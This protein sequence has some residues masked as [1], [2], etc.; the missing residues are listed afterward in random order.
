MS[1]CLLLPLVGHAAIS[2]PEEVVR[3]SVEGLRQAIQR[4]A[5]LIDQDPDRVIPL[6]EQHIMPNVNLD[7][8]VRLI[9]GSHWENAS[10]SQRTA[11]AVTFSQALL[12]TYG[13]HAKFY[14]DAV[15]DYLGVVPI[16]NNPT[17]VKVKTQ[18]RT[19]TGQSAQVD[20][21][22]ALSNGNWKAVDATVDGISI[23]RTYRIALNEEI[24]QLGIDG[25]IARIT[26]QPPS[27]RAHNH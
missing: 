16:T 10:P 19:A 17:V 2:T 26:Q 15:V 23:V 1:L 27:A 6:I 13:Y 21:R 24:R 22:M 14:T 20:Y 4:D 12:H 25:V 11:F 8:F 7:I 5:V 9:L 18:V 3:T